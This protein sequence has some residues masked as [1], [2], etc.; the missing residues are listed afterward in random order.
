M[1]LDFDFLALERVLFFNGQ[2]LTASD[3]TAAQNVNREMRWLHNRS[4][5]QWGIGA[6]MAVTGEKGARE[7]SVAP[8]YALDARGREIVLAEAV[9]LAVPPLAGPAILDLTIAY[10]SDD[11][12]EITETRAGV[13]QPGGAVRLSEV[14]LLRWLETSQVRTGFDIVLARVTI[15]NCQLDTALSLAQRRNARPP[16]QPRIACGQ[17]PDG[18]TDW[19]PWIE[20]IQSSNQAVVTEP[21]AGNGG[22]ETNRK[23]SDIVF[24]FETDVDTT[25]AQF[26]TTPCYQA[27]VGGKRFVSVKID[28]PGSLTESRIVEF[29]VEGFAQVTNARPEGFTLQVLMV[30]REDILNP[31]G[32]F[33]PEFE[34]KARD[35]LRNI[36]HVV[37]IGIEG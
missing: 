25:A 9:K 13:C 34:Q 19:K 20:R 6:G 2:R 29:L 27:R 5:H 30:P 28:L 36:W 23:K 14:P 11:E 17:T 22:A 35:I 12:V 21:A 18:G 10:P 7:I 31:P 16:Q 32:L 37:W 33:E 4:L 3:L 15:R 1:T 8:G 26:L 24:G